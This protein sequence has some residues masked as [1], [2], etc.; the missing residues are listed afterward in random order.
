MKEQ[1]T[2]SLDHD[3]ILD[4]LDDLKDVQLNRNRPS[5][6]IKHGIRSSIVKSSETR[7]EILQQHLLMTSSNNKITNNNNNIIDIKDRHFNLLSTRIDGTAKAPPIE[8]G[9]SEQGL[10]PGSGLVA[11][12]TD[13]EVEEMARKRARQSHLPDFLNTS[14]VK[15]SSA[16]MD[17]VHALHQQRGIASS[18]APLPAIPGQTSSLSELNLSLNQSA[19]STVVFTRDVHVNIVHVDNSN[20]HDSVVA[21]DLDHN[22]DKCMRHEGEREEGGE[23]DKEEG[24]EDIQWEEDE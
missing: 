15:G 12:P 6:N 9:P 13:D 2:R 5:T 24:D 20:S 4:M 17:Q 10:G 1:L 23:G 21:L 11:P 16:I 8:A 22:N 3:G 19:K 18:S 14:G 7:D